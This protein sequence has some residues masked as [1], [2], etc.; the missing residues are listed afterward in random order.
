MDSA[1]LLARGHATLIDPPK[2]EE[3]AIFC[4]FLAKNERIPNVC[5]ISKVRSTKKSVGIIMCKTFLPQHH[6]IRASKVF[7][8]DKSRVF[9]CRWHSQNATN[10][11]RSAPVGAK[12]APLA[13]SATICTIFYK[14]IGYLFVFLVKLDK[15][16]DLYASVQIFA[17]PFDAFIIL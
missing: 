13:P 3:V 4:C 7:S 11:L 14:K 2:H 5:R 8:D 10:C 15:A 17:L 9:P 6:M 16:A 12:Q 1:S